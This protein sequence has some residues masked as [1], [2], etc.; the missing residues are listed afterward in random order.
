[1]ARTGNF[2][3][4]NPYRVDW[5][6]SLFPMAASRR[7]TCQSGL[8][9]AREL[10]RY[11]C[12]VKETANGSRCCAFGEARQAFQVIAQW[13]FAKHVQVNEQGRAPQNGEDKAQRKAHA[14]AQEKVGFPSPFYRSRSGEGGCRSFCLHDVEHLSEGIRADPAGPCERMIK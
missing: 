6:A 12:K 14:R 1:M 11:A 7:G 3:N 10:F 5:R 9:S 13:R 2:R 4:C 8:A